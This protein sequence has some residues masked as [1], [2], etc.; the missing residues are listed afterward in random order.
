MGQG[1]HLRLACFTFLRS[2]VRR[3]AREEGAEG[4]A[5]IVSASE[6]GS[7]GAAP[8]FAT[9][10]KDAEPEPDVLVEEASESRVFCFFFGTEASWTELK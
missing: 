2:A 9:I 5:L 1:C 6:S 3:L 7:E 4:A 10:A 8:L